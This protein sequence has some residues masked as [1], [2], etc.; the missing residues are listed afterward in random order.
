M[1]RAI[2]Y[3]VVL[4]LPALMALPFAQMSSAAGA[5]I[6]VRHT[7]IAASGG[8]APAGGNYLNFFNAALN[9]RHEVAFD[10]ILGGP[11]FTTG[12]FVGDGKTTSTIALG[13][14]PDPAAPSFGTVFN[15]FITP[16]GDVV[17]NVNFSDFFR[18]DG[19]TIVP[20]VRNGDQAPGG[21]TLEPRSVYA[22]N[23]HGA[24]AYGARVSGSTATQGIFRSEG[25]Q[26]VAIARD[27]N[28]APT[29]GRFTSLR[30]PVINDR[31]QVAF[32]SEMTGGSAD[33][34]IFRGEGGDLT[35]VFVANQIASGGGIFTD[36]GNPVINAHGQVA[37]VGLLTNSASRAGL[38]VGDG[39]DAVAIALD[40]QPA[41]KGGSYSDRFFAPTRLNDRG[42]VAYIVGLAGGTG[43]SGIFRGDGD[44]TTT[45]ALAG[46]TA[47][48][49]A[50]TFQSFDDIKLGND[51]RVAFIARLAVGVGG[52]DSSNN[53]GIW[54]GTSDEDLQL[55]VR[56]G[57][58]VGGNVL[59]SLPQFG[60]GNQFDMNENGVLWIGSFGPAKAVVFSR[61]LAENDGLGE[62]DDVDIPL[63]FKNGTGQSL[64]V[65]GH[66]YVPPADGKVRWGNTSSC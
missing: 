19:K 9:A 37:V 56:T 17:F 30:D 54:I 36:F 12:V 11:P 48:G 2:L 62:D 28:D 40:G 41:P 49:T 51:G 39:A 38:F 33:F 7:V 53:R 6:A 10:A 5:K 42:E 29:G 8:A 31:G 3:T 23:D 64:R 21:G 18:S 55:V 65:Y 63:Q 50:G 13:A 4:L 20:L 52:V 47:P 25:T 26:T 61:I 45:V 15:P 32:S 66:G 59:T 60:Q 43:P 24:V 44:R 35:P 22:A 46:T 14:N 27:D 58:V 34:G 57:D 16:N 1:K